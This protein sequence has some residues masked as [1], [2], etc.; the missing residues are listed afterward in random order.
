MKEGI[1]THSK[2][3]CTADNSLRLN[4]CIN[5]N[6]YPL[7]IQKT[8]SITKTAQILQTLSGKALLWLFVYYTRS[9]DQCKNYSCP[10][11]FV[12]EVCC[13]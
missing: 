2:T 6:K 13:H 3:L 4:K 1:T 11:G 12:N 9:S 10:L 8:A 5:Y 7:E